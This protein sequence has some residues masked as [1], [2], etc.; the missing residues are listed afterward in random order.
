MLEMEPNFPRAKLIIFPCMEKGMYPW[1]LTELDQWPE[2]AWG[3][4]MKTYAY[5]KPGI[6]RWREYIATS[7]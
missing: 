7:R 2:D 4:M 5:S 3:M 6:P 1:V